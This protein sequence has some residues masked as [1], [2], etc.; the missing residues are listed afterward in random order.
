MLFIDLDQIKRRRQ[1]QRQRQILDKEREEETRKLQSKR[2]QKSLLLVSSLEFIKVVVVVVLGQKKGDEIRRDEE[3][4]I[5]FG[6]S[7]SSKS[8]GCQPICDPN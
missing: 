1:R 7:G 2:N 3:A 5:R 4:L 8:Y 6:C